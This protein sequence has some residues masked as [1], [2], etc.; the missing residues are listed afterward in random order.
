MTDHDAPFVPARPTRCFEDLVVGEVRRS[1]PRLVTEAEILAFARQWDPQWFHSDADLARQSVFGEVV[2]SGIHTLALWRQMDHA[3][4]ADI[5]FVCGIGW[6]EVRMKKA[7]RAGDSI[8]VTSEI[9][10]LRPSTSRADRGTAITRY[11]VVNQ[12][13]EEAVSFRS[14]NLVYT[15]AGRERPESSAS[16]SA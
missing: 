16:T 15:R 7:V 13:G 10:E 9:V 2:A 6:D 5:D 12:H 11:A 8:H 3:I 4:N 14:I 1:E